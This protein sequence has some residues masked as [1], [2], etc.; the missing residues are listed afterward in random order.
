MFE[1]VIFLGNENIYIEELGI[2]KNLV[3]IEN[4]FSPLNNEN[5]VSDKNQFIKSIKKAI[6]LS[7][8]SKE[9]TFLLPDVIFTSKVLFF[10]KFPIL[11][12]KKEELIHWK[13]HNYLP[14][15][16]SLYNIQ[17]SIFN[18]NVLTFA[19]PNT[20][21]NVLNECISTV[22]SD[23]Y[24]IFPEFLY[25]LN[26]LKTSNNT[27]CILIIN[28]KNYFTA[29]LIDNGVPLLIRTRVKNTTINMKEEIA[30]VL[31]IV[32]EKLNWTNEKIVV[33]GNKLEDYQ[34]IIQRWN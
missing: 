12:K 8:K 31:K 20:W 34:T 21:Y 30:T 6:N 26:K 15:K 11:L 25:I 7:G 27:N 29:S 32:K 24:N 19:L 23:C 2:E 33:F 5:I 17:Y 22:F 18:Q 28:R 14:A 3:P 1:Q 4:S 13:L 9:M 16:S 10:E